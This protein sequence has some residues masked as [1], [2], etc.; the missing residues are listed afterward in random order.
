MIIYNLFD[1]ITKVI[2]ME[3]TVIRSS[4]KTVGIQVDLNGQIIVRAPMRFP[5][6]KIKK[7]VEEN[8]EWIL[9]AQNKQETAKNNRLT[10]SNEDIARLKMLAKDVLT[11]KTEYYADVMGVTFGTVKITSAEKRFG[12]CSGS[13][14]IC[15]SYKLMLYPDEA[16]DYVVVH[17]LAHTVHHNHSADFYSFVGNILPDYK[18]R[19][20]LLSGKQTF[21]F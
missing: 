14:N 19:E 18:K 3:Y 6:K 21:P 20:K 1:I 7:I 9:K 10:L 4:R 15:Y 17:E 11:K 16:V 2:E 13:N 8:A 12:S 5:E